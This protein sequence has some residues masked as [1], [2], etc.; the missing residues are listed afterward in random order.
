MKDLCRRRRVLAA[1][2]LASLGA[3]A[4]VAQ[5]KK[6]A[7][8]VVLSRSEF[9][10]GAG[11]ALRAALRDLGQVEGRTYVFEIRHAGGDNARLRELAVEVA[12]SKPDIILAAHGQAAIFAK[13]ATSSIPIVFSAVD[14]VAEGLVA[15]LA[16]PGGNATGVAAPQNELGTKRLELLRD[17]LPAL[18]LV[19]VLHT[20]A[21]GSLSQVEFLKVAAMRMKIEILPVPVHGDAEIGPAIERAVQQ[22]A[23]AIMHIAAPLFGIQK[24]LIIALA[25]KHRIPVIAD[26]RAFVEAGGLMAYGPKSG[27]GTVSM[28]SLI[29]RILKGARP[30]DLAVEQPRDFEFQINARTARALGITIPGSVLMR[31]DR[32]IE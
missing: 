2:A 32:V 22:R 24:D 19:A 10:A 8:I 18:K 25:A 9:P 16:R 27:Q 7:R 30:A 6:P 26:Y 12:R 4:A 29:D 11:Q 14:P 13:A 3:P 23:Q 1:L 31:A 21:P 17:A 15:S 5:E 28:A 20:Q